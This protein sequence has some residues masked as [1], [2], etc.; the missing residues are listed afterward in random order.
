[1]MTR[2]KIRKETVGVIK[3]NPTGA[4]MGK[5]KSILMV[6]LPLMCMYLMAERA[7]AADKP[8]GLSKK[9][10][11][12][13][14]KTFPGSKIKKTEKEKWQGKTVTEIELRAADGILYEVF[15]S[16]DGTIQKI[17]EEDEWRWFSK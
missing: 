1:M 16:E 9:I 6:I 7:A 12:T 14:E 15:V 10:K 13:I 4:N 11:Q 8:E 3:Q 5:I 17:E 2:G